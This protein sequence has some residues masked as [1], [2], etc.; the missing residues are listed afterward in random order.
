MPTNT[1]AKK[2][3]F[4]KTSKSLEEECPSVILVGGKAR[5]KIGG[6]GLHEIADEI[7]LLFCG[8]EQFKIPN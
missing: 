8:F 1:A 4:T 5:G 2:N 6:S 3:M 7:A